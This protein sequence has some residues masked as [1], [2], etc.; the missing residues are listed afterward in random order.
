MVWRAG[1]DIQDPQDSQDGNILEVWWSWESWWPGESWQ[2]WMSWESWESWQGRQLAG[3]G[4]AARWRFHGDAVR[5]LQVGNLYFSSNAFLQVSTYLKWQ[6]VFWRVVERAC[7]LR[8]SRACP[9]RRSRVWRRVCPLRRSRVCPLRLMPIWPSVSNPP[10]N[11]AKNVQI[12][13]NICNQ[14]R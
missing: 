12:Q 8:R 9:L 4:L 3:K 6:S 1:Q 10:E 14:C 7:P 11:G 5:V 2:S 13:E